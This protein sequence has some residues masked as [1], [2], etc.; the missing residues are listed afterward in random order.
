MLAACA[1]V[2]VTESVP[3]IYIPEE[4]DVNRG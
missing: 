4:S 2:V 1:V 3:L